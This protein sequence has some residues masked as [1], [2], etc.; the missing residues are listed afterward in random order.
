MSYLEKEI[1]TI[2]DSTKSYLS[3]QL[4]SEWYEENM[5]MPIGTAFP[6]KFSFDLTPYWREILD[7]LSPFHPAKEVSIMKGAQLGGT[8]AV[9]N[10]I[11]GYTISQNPG[12]IMLLTGHSDLSKDAMIKIDHMIDNSGLRDLIIPSVLR[13]RNSRSGDT[14]KSKEFAG[15]HLKAGSVTNHNLL[16]QHDVMIML[17]DDYDAAPSKSKQAGATRELVQQR[18]AAFAHKKKIY[19]MSSPQIEGSSNIEEVFMFGDQ[20]YYN[21]PCPKCGEFIVFKWSTTIDGSDGKENAGIAYKVKNGTVVKNSVGYVCEKCGGWFD[22]SQKYEMN[23]A[24]MWVSSA[25]SKEQDHYSYQISSLY[26]PPGMYSWDF[27]AQQFVNANPEEG[28]RNESKH[29]T[30]M[31][32]VLGETYRQQGKSIKASMLEKNIR[33]Y[34]IGTLPEKISMDDGNGRIVLVTCAADLNG[35]TDDARLDYEVVAWSESGS[36]YSVDHG[37]IGTFIFRET[38]KQKKVPRN[39][40]TYE[41]NKQNSVWPKLTEI[42]ERV[43]FTDT[44]NNRPM[45]VMISGVDTGFWTTLVYDYLGSVK[46]RLLCIGVKGDKPDKFV[47]PD[48]NTPLFRIMQERKDSYMVAV[49]RIK[50]DL[51][52]YMSL[53]WDE[54]E[55]DGQPP[56]FMNF[57]TPESGKYIYRDYFA[58]FESEIRVIDKDGRSF[59]W[60]K[61]T[62]ISQNHLFDCRVY[63]LS[64][65][66]IITQIICKE[67][68]LTESLWEYFVN[69]VNM[70]RK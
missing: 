27:Y 36:S 46:N 61:K 29:Q 45:K 33:K 23:L 30:F 25:Q 55:D 22:D 65:K 70:A 20:R 63:N 57:P 49:N 44:E 12:N 51:A 17:V 58:H 21:V 56:N 47:N 50:D 39:K 54:R 14:D 1:A 66:H 11:I 2:I 32:V 60:E 26:A 10:A 48:T 6:G 34:E 41:H 19:W 59:K 28:E 16:R 18:T 35:K 9:L 40:M 5:V 13:K 38:E 8:V 3:N 62:T 15:G 69:A 43:Y 67:R 53:K 42:L 31:N 7:C 68:K 4:P 24:G 52:E 64:L 37:S